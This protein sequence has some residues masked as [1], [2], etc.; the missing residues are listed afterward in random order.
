MHVMVVMVVV[1]VAEQYLRENTVVFTSQ[2]DVR[3]ALT[4][5]RAHYP[6]SETA[7]SQEPRQHN[8]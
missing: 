6:L 4:I 2:K 1:V 8:N 7:A 5:A 3:A